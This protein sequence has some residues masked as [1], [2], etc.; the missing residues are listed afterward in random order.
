MIKEANIKHKSNKVIKEVME[1]VKD[2]TTETK[3]REK[4]LNNVIIFNLPESNSQLKSN[5]LKHIRE[6]V[7]ELC[8]EVNNDF[9]DTDITELRRLKKAKDDKIRPVLIT[10]SKNEKKRGLLRKL[11]HLKESQKCKNIKIDHDK[12]KQER[13]ELKKFYEEA[14]KQEAAD[15]TGNYLF[16]VRGPPW[17]RKIKKI[18]KRH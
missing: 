9:V 5:R 14:K 2:Q 13:E 3:G 11:F 1:V 16:R 17:D 4:R 12:T 7:L 10:L 6:S 8:T 18:R 15:K